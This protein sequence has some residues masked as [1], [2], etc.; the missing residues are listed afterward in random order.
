MDLARTMVITFKNFTFI[1]GHIVKIRI[2]K[3]ANTLSMSLNKQT[4]S[5][6]NQ[7][8]YLQTHCYKK[9]FHNVLTTALM[10]NYV[11]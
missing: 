8:S 5:I 9:T 11:R 4:K 2:N 10:V 7:Q 3:C 6:M 1:S